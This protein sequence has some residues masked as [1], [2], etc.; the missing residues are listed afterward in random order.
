MNANKLVL[1]LACVGSGLVRAASIPDNRMVAPTAVARIAGGEYCFAHVRELQPERTPPSYLI[2]RLKIQVAWRNSG[3]RPMIV[4][5]EHDRT[6]YTSLKP[7]VMT[8]FHEI[9]SEGLTPSIAPLE[10]LPAKVNPDNP[11][12]PKNDYFSIIPARGD[13]IASQMEEI[14]F[15]V[16]HR[17]LLR[18]DPDL[19]GKK[20]YIRLELK[21]QELTP[22]LLTA[23]SD[24]WTKFGVPWTGSAMTN[25]MTVQVPRQ[26]E[27]APRCVDG[28]FETPGNKPQ[29]TGK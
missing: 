15:P 27:Q 21:P 23:L 20:L 28:S 26:I 14:A 5:V 19:R 18:H 1:I 8:V 24:R 4:P 16:N 22:S 25:V 29:D 6:V 11:V 3:M 12:D 9:P 10:A 13:L 2:L 7:G 17:G